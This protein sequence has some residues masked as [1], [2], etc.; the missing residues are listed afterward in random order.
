MR[1]RFSFVGEVCCTP[2][3]LWFRVYH[4]Y[5]SCLLAGRKPRHL[6]APPPVSP[7]AGQLAVWAFGPPGELCSSDLAASL[8]GSCRL[9][10][11]ALGDDAAPRT[12]S[13]TVGTLLD[14]GVVGLARLRCA[15][16]LDGVRASC[17][18]CCRARLGG[19]TA[20]S[21][22]CIADADSAHVRMPWDR[23]PGCLATHPTSPHAIATTNATAAFSYTLTLTSPH[24]SLKGR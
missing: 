9:A 6:P 15:L 10:V 11:V 16:Q 21:C 8:A 20:Q 19:S 17:R 7:P 5:C 18:A 14:Q 1:L 23:M 24:L 2:S 4:F 13:P 12:T 22:C 3:R